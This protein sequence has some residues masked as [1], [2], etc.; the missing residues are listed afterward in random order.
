MPIQYFGHLKGEL[1]HLLLQR[2]ILLFFNIVLFFGYYL[3]VLVYSSAFF[4]AKHFLTQGQS[5]TIRLQIVTHNSGIKNIVSLL[6]II[7]PD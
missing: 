3:G 7:C 6:S 2:T 1:K 5:V 4:S